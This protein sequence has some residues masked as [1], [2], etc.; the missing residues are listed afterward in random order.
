MNKMVLNVDTESY[1]VEL[2][3][4][5]IEDVE[6][7]RSKKLIFATA[8]KAANFL[9]IPPNKFYERIGVGKYAY[10]K[11]TDKKYAVRKVSVK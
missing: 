4:M 3:D 6:E 7:R 11:E 1:P 5:S 9:G 2:Y 8:M 10:A